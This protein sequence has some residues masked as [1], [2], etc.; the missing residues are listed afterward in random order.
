MTSA[1][2]HSA[3]RAPDTSPATRPAHVGWLPRR[4]LGIDIDTDAWAPVVDVTGPAALRLLDAFTIDGVPAFAAPLGPGG[5]DVW[6]VWVGTRRYST[7]ERTMLRVMPAI[8]A[9][10]PDALR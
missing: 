5:E 3:P 6:R 2:Y 9:E 1:A 8:L 10:H 4:G 7:A